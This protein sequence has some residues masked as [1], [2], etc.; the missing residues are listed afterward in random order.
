M[1][2][3]ANLA[4]TQSEISEFNFNCA[5]NLVYIP[6]IKIPSSAFFLAV[7][8]SNGATYNYQIFDHTSS[9][10]D[11]IASTTITPSPVNDASRPRCVDFDWSGKDRL[12]RMQHDGRIFLSTGYQSLQTISDVFSYVISQA[13]SANEIM[14]VP[15]TDLAAIAT[16]NGKLI[17]TSAVSDQLQSKIHVIQ[18]PNNQLVRLYHIPRT[19]D[20]A[21]LFFLSGGSTIQTYTVSQAE[22]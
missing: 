5:G 21:V 16:Y 17:F 6:T 9:N 22:C 10:A 13:A 12:L 14:W 4:V 8:D 18:H 2:V 7:S 11:S 19:P 20:I 1:L 15:F 3:R